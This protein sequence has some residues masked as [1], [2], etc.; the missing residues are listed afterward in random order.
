MQAAKLYLGASPLLPI[1]NHQP[2]TRLTEGRKPAASGADFAAVLA[3]ER[4]KAVIFSQHA[5][6]RL[7]ERGIAFTEG[8]LAQL[9]ATI[10]KMAAKGARESLICLKDAALIVNVPN[11]TVI[12]AM[13]GTSARETIFTN[14]DS[15][16]IL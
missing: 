16:A 12:T 10:D 1:Q 3:E 14:I 6:Q 7:H 13:D 8:D 2:I 9:D 4:Q 11:R 5:V 15:A